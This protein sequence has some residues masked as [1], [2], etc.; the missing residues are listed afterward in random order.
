[1]A[2]VRLTRRGRATVT[3]VA[4][5]VVVALGAWL[6]SG[7]DHPAAAPPRSQVSEPPGPTGT[8]PLAHLPLT[9][10]AAP[11]GVPD[12]PAVFIKVD[13][14]RSA[15]PQIGLR[16]ADLIVEELAEGGATRL[17]VGYQSVL[18]RLVGP[19]R[20]VRTSDI[21]IVAPTQ[22]LL[23]ASGGAAKAVR[24]LTRAGIPMAPFEG[25]GS[26]RDP[27]RQ[28]PYNL[29]VRPADVLAA[30]RPLP[31]PPDYLSWR[32]PGAARAKLSGR[33]ARRVDARFS[34][35]HT[36]QWRYGGKR[37]WQRVGDLAAPADAFRATNLI[38]VRVA[39]RDAG[40]RDPAGNPV[41][42]TVTEGTGDATLLLGGRAVS[43]QWHKGEAADAWEFT[44]P[45][46]AAIAVPT[47]RTWIELVPESGAVTVS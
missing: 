4:A 23:V 33:T 12:R 10:R 3:A 29:F 21:G 44:T 2:A 11:S 37:G 43:A 25:A 42:E 30:V 22:G 34:P 24:A 47:G 46:G 28:R 39:V 40:Y 6:L 8:E 32:L 38:V 14:T 45:A 17:V 31:K 9:G 20:S 13:N 41:P 36:T 35:S 18:P 1:M 27:T 5:V 19:V 26:Q 16:S 15:R 7:R